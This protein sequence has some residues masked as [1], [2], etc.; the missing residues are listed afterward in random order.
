[1]TDLK[2]QLDVAVEAVNKTVDA[3]SIHGENALQGGFGLDEKTANQ[4]IALEEKLAS[5]YPDQKDIPRDVLIEH[6][7]TIYRLVGYPEDLADFAVDLVL[8]FDIH[9]AIKSRLGQ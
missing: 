1:M 6:Y 9:S 3:I 7:K 5:Q 2:D 4:I 8:N